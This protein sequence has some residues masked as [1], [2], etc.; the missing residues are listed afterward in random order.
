[1]AFFTDEEA[2]LLEA[3]VDQIVPVDNW[4]GA[5]DAGVAVFIDKQL[6]GPYICFQEK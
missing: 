3:I 6:T 1:M 2:K 5:K 4:P